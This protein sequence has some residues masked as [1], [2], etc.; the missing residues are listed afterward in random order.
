[1]SYS[2]D[3]KYSLSYS[4]KYKYSIIVIYMLNIYHLSTAKQ[5]IV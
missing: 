3:Y 2:L 5:K 1:M 4:I